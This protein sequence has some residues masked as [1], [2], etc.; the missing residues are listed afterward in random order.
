MVSLQNIEQYFSKKKVVFIIPIYFS[1][2]ATTHTTSMY[3][4]FTKNHAVY[5]V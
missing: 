2:I 4:V 1:D 5:K 3:E